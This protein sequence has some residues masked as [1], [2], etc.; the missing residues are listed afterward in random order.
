MAPMV[1]RS[2]FNKLPVLA[3]ILAM[4]A[5]VPAAAQRATSAGSGGVH[6]SAPPMSHVS[7]SPSP[8]LHSPI[9]RA[10][11][12]HVSIPAPR[13]VS[14]T[15]AGALGMTVFRPPRRPIHPRPPVWIVYQSPFLFG[16]FLGFNSCWWTDCGFFWT[17]DYANVSSPGPTNYVEPV[18]ETPVYGEEMPEVPQ[19]FLKD[20]TVL[21]VTDYWLVDGQLHFK[22]IEEDGEKPAEHMIPFEALDLQKTVDANTRRGFHFMLRNEPVEQYMRDHPEAPSSIASPHP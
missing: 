6:V 8:M 10:P 14:A 18:Y 12:A 17:T 5:I 4:C 3:G 1:R 16:P 13:I 9:I 22:I 21:N 11:M 20:G 15:S 19:L 2:I 7:I